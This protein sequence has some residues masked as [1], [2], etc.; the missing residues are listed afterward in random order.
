MCGDGLAHPA[1]LIG[2]E[3]G[4]QAPFCHTE[5]LDGYHNERSQSPH[6]QEW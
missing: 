3:D 1:S 5:R 4:G 6:R 2:I